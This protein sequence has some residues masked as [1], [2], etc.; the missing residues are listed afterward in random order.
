MHSGMRWVVL[1]LAAVQV[2]AL[3]GTT[4]FQQSSSRA[5]DSPESLFASNEAFEL[6]LEAPIH[7][8]FETARG[9][10]EASLKGTLTYTSEGGSPVALDGVDVSV[11]GH[12]STQETECAFPKLKLKLPTAP[13]LP[14]KG[15][16]SLKIGTHCGERP[17]GALSAKY[18]RWANEKA[19]HR[20]AF[21]YRLLKAMQVPTL[22]A[23]PARI[24]YVEPGRPPLVR[25]ALVLEDDAQALK[26]VGASSQISEQQFTSA[27]EALSP[28]DAV[29]LA[30]AEAMIGNFDWCLRFYQG[31]TYRCDGRHPLWNILAFKTAIGVTPVLYDFDLSGMVTQRHSWFKRIFGSFP[32]TEPEVEVLSQIQRTRTLFSRAELDAAR[33]EF[34]RDKPLAYRTLLQSNVDEQGTRAIEA[35][36]NSF[37]AV[38]ERDE[39]FYAPVV[40]AANTRVFVDAAGTSPAC[41][42]ESL[43]LGTPVSDPLETSG[44]RMRVR[45][46]NALWQWDGQSRKCEAAQ[47]DAVWVDSKAVSSDYPAR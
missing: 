17:D 2:A 32:G 25:N 7:Q 15:I 40:V 14:L 27:R 28:R 29:R 20:E 8:L 13:D 39:R 19:P 5:A 21:V 46:L 33:K 24:T 44:D 4:S 6:R 23:R 30:F 36:L 34:I 45:I 10:P 12:T 22:E 42:G 26:R 3:S 37:F 35:Y 43:L 1:L 18:G 38:I 16:D 41:G 9:N 31:D 11:R 47:N